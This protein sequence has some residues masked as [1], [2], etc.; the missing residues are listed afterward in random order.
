MWGGG[1]GTAPSS[2]SSKEQVTLLACSNSSG[3]HKTKINL[4]WCLMDSPSVGENQ[5]TDNNVT[6]KYYFKKKKNKLK[7]HRWRKQ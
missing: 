3:N 2:K 6:E 1:G 4:T 5:A 7:T